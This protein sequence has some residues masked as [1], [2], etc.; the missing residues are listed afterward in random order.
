MASKYILGI[1]TLQMNKLHDYGGETAN[2]LQ[3]LDQLGV[4][5]KPLPKPPEELPRLVDYHDPT[6]S[7]HLRARA[8]LHS[9]CAHCHRK[10]GGGNADFDLHASIPFSQSKAVNTQPG[11]GTFKLNNPKI[12]TPGEP[13][14]SLVLERMKIT[15]LGRM[16]HVASKVV[17]Q[18]A[19]DLIALWIAQ[20]S[21]Q[22][23]LEKS[24]AINPR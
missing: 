18:P 7:T 23:A 9:N 4:F 24:G 15:G 3:L 10:W 20:L 12:V 1:T 21:E 19:V 22:G 17:D 8:Y 6:A 16:P 5:S 2:Q 11:Q 14:R 13:A